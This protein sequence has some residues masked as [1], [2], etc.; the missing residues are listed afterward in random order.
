L[1][2]S[3]L[4]QERLK[5]ADMVLEIRDARIPFSSAN[6]ALDDAIGNKRRMIILNKADLADGSTKQV[7][8][9]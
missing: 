8:P 7:K 4:L 6:P 1:F 3:Y 9:Q 2:C 5:V